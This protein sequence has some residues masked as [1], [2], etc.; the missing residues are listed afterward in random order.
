MPKHQ[1]ISRRKSQA[2]WLRSSK[3]GSHARIF[4]DHEVIQLLREAI[5]RE[6]NQGAFARRHGI[7]RS[8]LNQILNQKK[9]VNRAV[10][11]ALELRRVYAAEQDERD[12]R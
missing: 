2:V 3:L 8:Y 5:E 10:L 4:D 12:P 6:G 9:P 7:E 11:R 1:K